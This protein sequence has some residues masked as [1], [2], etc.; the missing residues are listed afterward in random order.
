MLAAVVD[1]P[2]HVGTRSPHVSEFVDALDLES[3]EFDQISY[4]KKIH[5]GGGDGDPHVPP[6][7]GHPDLWGRW[8]HRWEGVVSR[9]RKIAGCSCWGLL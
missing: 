4:S 1:C 9:L 3:I 2:S 5:D 7:Y 8:A 6:H